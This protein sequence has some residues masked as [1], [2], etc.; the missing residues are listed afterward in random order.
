MAHTGYLAQNYT[1]EGYQSKQLTDTKLWSFA[2]YGLL[3]CSL[4]PQKDLLQFKMAS[5]NKTMIQK[6][7]VQDLVGICYKLPVNYIEAKDSWG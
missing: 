7:L 1:M 3:D 6:G 4:Q 5:Q 2:F